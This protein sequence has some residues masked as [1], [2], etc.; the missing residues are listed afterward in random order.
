VAKRITVYSKRSLIT[1]LFVAPLVTV[2]VTV[3]IF[4]FLEL[5]FTPR[6]S[7]A[8]L[9]GWG[10]IWCIGTVPTAYAATLLVAPVYLYFTSRRRRFVTLRESLFAGSITGSL[11]G[12]AWLVRLVSLGS[13]LERSGY[14]AV[15]TIGLVAGAA[16]A[17]ALTFMLRPAVAT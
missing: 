7:V 4:A 10:L 11:A 17:G 3:F 16:V 1:S 8:D 13:S 6:G 2:P 15:P 12:V 9:L 5:A 14:V